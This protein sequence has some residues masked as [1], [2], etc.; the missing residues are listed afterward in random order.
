MNGIV[1]EGEYKWS[2]TDCLDQMP[3]KPRIGASKGGVNHGR[4]FDTNLALQRIMINPQSLPEA[5]KYELSDY[6]R[7]LFN[8]HQIGKVC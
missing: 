4:V 6:P 1:L 5:F 8:N 2:K 7:S 3:V